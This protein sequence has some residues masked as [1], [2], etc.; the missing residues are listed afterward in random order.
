[1]NIPHQIIRASAGTGKTH[2]LTT[3]FIDLLHRHV[4]PDQILATTFTR[5][6]SGEILER[7]LQQLA[8][9]SQDDQVAAALTSDLNK[10]LLTPESCR[11]MLA[12]VCHNL[13]RI[14]ISTIDS[15]F[16]RVTHCFRHEL[17]VPPQPR[18]IAS[19]DP[20]A[21]RLR[22]EAIDAMLN[23]ESTDVLLDLLHHL[24]QHTAQRCVTKSIDQ[25]VR[26]LYDVYRLAPDQKTWSCLHVPP[27]LAEP[28]L[29]RAIADLRGLKEL[30]NSNKS[31]AKAWSSDKKKAEQRQWLR[32][33]KTGL[34]A[35]IADEMDTFRNKP[36]PQF[37]IGA[38]RPLVEHAKAVLID[39]VANQT[40]A[41][42]ELLRQFDLH[43]TRLRQENQV[44]L[45]SD[46]PLKL[47]RELPALGE[48]AAFDIYYRLDMKATHLM[49]DEFQD[50]SIEQWEVLRPL[51][52]EVLAHSDGSRTFFCVGD[53]KQAIYGWR[54]GCTE[55][56]DQIE[57]DPNFDFYKQ[58]SM[59][60]SYRSSQVVLDAI[61]QV[62][63]TLA[64]KP[65]LQEYRK[66]IDEWHNQFSKHQAANQRHS[67]YVELLESPVKDTNDHDPGVGDDESTSNR[68]SAHESFAAEQIERIATSLP[69][70]S[71][72]VL[73][74]RNNTVKTLINLLHMRGVTASGEA[75]NSLTDDPA[76][77]VI[78][79]ALRMAD[80]PA[81][82]ISAFH[83][84][85]SPLAPLINLTGWRE[86][87]THPIARTIRKSL[88]S[89]GYADLI[90]QWFRGL[91]AA[92]EER[93]VVRLTQ[94]LQ[95]ADQYDPD[96]SLQPTE[97]VDYVENTPVEEAD[98]S[99]VRVMTI[100]KSKGLEFD[101]TVLPD[102]DR[103]LRRQNA[104]LVDVDRP[105][106]T[107]PIQAVYRSTN[108]FVRN[109]SPQLTNAHEQER[110]RRLRDDLCTL[111]VAMTR[112]RDSLHMF[113][114]PMKHSSPRRPPSNMTY[115][116]IL[117]NALA[118]DDPSLQSKHHLYVA[119]TSV[120]TDDTCRITPSR[121]VGSCIKKPVTIDL[122][123]PRH[124]SG[125][126]WPRLSPSSLE[127]DNRIN[128]VQLLSTQ[129]HLGQ[130]RGSILHK[131][132]EKIRFLDD[133][134]DGIPYDQDLLPEATAIDSKA[135]AH[136]LHELLTQFRTMLE[137]SA[138]R[139]AL[140]PCECELW[141]ERAFAVRRD[142]HLVQGQFDRVMIFRKSGKILG[143]KLID[144]KTY[145]VTTDQLAS[146]VKR[147]TPQMNAYRD[148]L[149]A[150]LD[151]KSDIVTTCLLFVDPGYL[152]VI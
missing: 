69:G 23:D 125:R 89:C 115:A 140:A 5:K 126:S 30:M 106:P 42:F 31:M 117:R 2:Q 28:E 47:S 124:R 43:Y 107:E 93:S 85:N 87:D 80:H 15:F 18:I 137:T 127:S 135:D 99:A 108:K 132:F 41:T 138:V 120:G 128:V 121:L 63:G 116:T 56:F 45:F 57:N 33:L 37:V 147:H 55:I 67:G 58:Q 20:L 131:W 94:L 17:G 122:A 90:S 13:H 102:L 27:L 53:V 26:N 150:M 88:L 134:S 52:E 62:F 139:Q 19:D 77:A 152:C 151:I 144:F 46:L 104:G 44:L 64:D 86:R 21:I 38:Y 16:N 96:L 51:A 118:T 60:K 98:P 34:A 83:V 100:H 109:Q 143:A 29:D 72:G 8:S 70:R 39:H 4:A 123:K 24:H 54:G 61:N 133:D 82:S 74:T 110:Y 92:C 130:L 129:T 136:W 91:T 97:F 111:Y 40:K 59:N 113:I 22:N 79:S 81:D 78:L 95:L 65:F 75:G 141:R 119:G 9:A 1:M 48:Q 12:A 50:T 68:A 35:K 7:I 32:F 49:F 84:F 6:A 71:V 142:R 11:Q 149:S 103:P 146:A 25:I 112:A 76:V 14:S 36:I 101:A 3:Q 73:V 105:T 10:P 66:N 114:K 148:A 145:P